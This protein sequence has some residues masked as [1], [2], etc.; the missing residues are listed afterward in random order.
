[1][2][3]TTTSQV[4]EVVAHRGGAL[5][6]THIEAEEGGTPLWTT[7]MTSLLRDVAIE[8]PSA[9]RSVA[10]HGSAAR[11]SDGAAAVPEPPGDA[12]VGAADAPGTG[13][14]ATV[15]VAATA[16]HVYTECARIWNPIHTDPAVAKAAGL[17]GIILH[18][19]ATL[20]LGISRAIELAN[21]R[22]E[23]VARVGGQ[24]RAM[25][26]M[27]SELVV[28]VTGRDDAGVRFDVWTAEGRAAVRAGFVTWRSARSGRG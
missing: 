10:A 9:D 8:G 3:V 11:A 18:G 13:D 7:R 24:F 4:A 21:G 5:V 15:P 23:D 28:R 19:T 12:G 27:P 20:A 16:A 26:L 6:V 2:V 1:M 14:A 25:V 22:P 17:P